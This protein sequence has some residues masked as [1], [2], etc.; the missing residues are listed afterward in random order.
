[1]TVRNVDYSQLLQNVSDVYSVDPALFNWIAAAIGAVIMGA[2]WFGGALQ[3]SEKRALE[4]RLALAK[5]QSE[6]ANKK[7]DSL[8]AEIAVLKE[9]ME[10]HAPALELAQATARVD[11]AF[12]RFA[13]ANNQVT[14]TLTNLGVGYDAGMY[15][16]T[17]LPL[18]MSSNPPS[19]ATPD[20]KPEVTIKSNS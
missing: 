15:S 13:D 12:A 8:Q 6:D 20:Q 5:E 2:F 19:G 18:R 14:R 9:K 17:P 16:G 11:G 4:Q 10:R 1:M 7:R 3:K